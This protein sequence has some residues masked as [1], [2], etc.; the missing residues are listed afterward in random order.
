MVSN[1]G[2]PRV[3]LAIG[4]RALERMLRILEGFAVEHAATVNEVARALEPQ[5]FDMI[6]VG[7]H[8]DSSNAVGAVKLVLS[9]APDVPLACVHALPFSVGLG[10]AALGAFRAACEE[11]GVD[12]FLDLREFPDDEAGNARVRAMLERLLVHS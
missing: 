5:H 8:F 2:R 3:L 10:E 7:S 6:I 12:S 11:L 1:E 9:R 4:P